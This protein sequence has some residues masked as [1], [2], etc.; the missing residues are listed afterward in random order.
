MKEP[1]AACIPAIWYGVT[2]VVKD[3]SGVGIFIQTD[4]GYINRFRLTIESA[5]ALVDAL[6][7]SHLK[8]LALMRAHRRDRH[9]DPHGRGIPRSRDDPESP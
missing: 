8:Q 7:D 5:A 6:N 4:E 9:C 2:P 3:G 1:L